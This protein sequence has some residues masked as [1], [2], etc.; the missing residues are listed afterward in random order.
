MMGQEIV[1][2]VCGDDRTR[3]TL[4]IV[5]ATQPAVCTT[6][7]VLRRVINQGLFSCGGNKSELRPPYLV[8]GLMG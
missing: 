5:R 1:S 6:S 3:T 4:Q 8:A 2:E 7:K